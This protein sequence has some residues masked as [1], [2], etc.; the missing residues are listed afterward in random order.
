MDENTSWYLGENIDM[1]A[2]NNKD[3]FDEDFEESNKMHGNQRVYYYELT[4]P[5]SFSCSLSH[6]LTRISGIFSCVLLLVSV[7]F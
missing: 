1:F 7:L 5:F 2:R 4:V 3:P 6:I